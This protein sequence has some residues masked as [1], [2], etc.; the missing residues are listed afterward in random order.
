MRSYFSLLGILR[1]IATLPLFVIFLISSWYLIFQYNLGMN[2]K[3]LRHE[4]SIALDLANLSKE[5][6]KEMIINDTNSKNIN[7]Q[8]TDH[9]IEH[10]KQL[11][12]NELG[13]NE[14]L[15]RLE[16][17]PQIRYTLDDVNLNNS[18]V[19]S[20][21]RDLNLLIKNEIFNLRDH[22][23]SNRLNLFI[24]TFISSYSN[25]ISISAKRDLVANIINHR[26]LNT[27]ELLLWLDLIRNNGLNY[28]YLPDSYAKKQ[29]EAIFKS[30]NYKQAIDNL[31]TF[32]I[33][34]IKNDEPSIYLA[35]KYYD[36]ISD[37]L[38]F[39]Y[40]IQDAISSQIKTELNEFEKDLWIDSI[41]AFIVWIISI[42]LSLISYYTKNYIKANIDNLSKI[43][44]K[45]K[46]VSAT[47]PLESTQTA[48]LE[49]GHKIINEALD[50]I[51]AQKNI[52][53]SDSRS[54]TAFLTNISHEIKA[55]LNGILGFSELLKSRSLGKDEKELIDIIEQSSQNLLKVINNII[56]MAKIEGGNVELYESDFSL[57]TLF[58]EIINSYFNRLLAKNL[59]LTYYIDPEL[60]VTVFS[61]ED[62]IR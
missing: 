60:M 40:Q 58:D 43:I 36:L 41:L 39:S 50:K 42:I 2:L 29:I 59:T 26:A 52:A 22:D 18:E 9:T 3:E 57:Y 38:E 23:L 46:S 62:K 1:L 14:I 53:Q 20:Y 28:G 25:S 54:K 4:F 17:L 55:P 32:T 15:N 21:F 31:S 8:I 34:L 51:I 11:H 30:Q 5:L 49:N 47:N 10:I 24:F 16:F 33:E 56:N 7:R 35:Q 61:D 48:T 13:L 27:Q 19:L 6:D 45:I 37:E 12:S 44:D